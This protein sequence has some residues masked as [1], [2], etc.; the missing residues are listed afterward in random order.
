LGVGSDRKDG[1]EGPRMEMSIRK[2]EVSECSEQPV[3]G[4]PVPPIAARLVP[5]DSLHSD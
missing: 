5:Y 3:K 2:L 4:A 1:H